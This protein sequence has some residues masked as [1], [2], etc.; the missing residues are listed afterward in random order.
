MSI[1]YLTDKEIAKL[2]FRSRGIK[3]F[4]RTV[5][6]IQELIEKFNS[7]PIKILE[8][9]CGFA[10]L[11]IELNLIYG[12]KVELHGLNLEQGS[13][14]IEKALRIAKHKGTVNSNYQLN[15]KT[16][17]FIFH[18][19][20]LPLPFSNN[21]F[22]VIISQFS[23]VYIQNKIKLLT[24]INRIIKEEGLA[25]IWVGFEH[26]KYGVGYWNTLEI[27]DSKKRVSLSTFFKKYSNLTYRRRRSG[28]VL[29]IKKDTTLNFPLTL[30]S[31][32][33][34]EMKNKNFYGYKSTYLAINDNSSKV[35]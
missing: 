28:S 29:E 11:L 6:P 18:D 30:I 32:I 34:M 20:E 19:A 31:S 4:N 14:N 25:S 12:D 9:G 13:I 33:N 16:I 15:S 8:I 17:N 22:D 23:F 24:E 1:R 10:Q 2:P 26:N 7:H 35:K 5:F 21:Y 3:D 27:Y